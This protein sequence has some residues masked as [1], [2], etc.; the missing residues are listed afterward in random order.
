MRRGKVVLALVA[1]LATVASAQVLEVILETN[2]DPVMAG[3]GDV[4]FDVMVYVQMTGTMGGVESLDISIVTVE[5]NASAEAREVIV[6]FPPPP[7]G[8]GMAVWEWNIA[9]MSGYLQIDPT[10]TDVEPDNDMDTKNIAAAAKTSN[11]NFTLGTTDDYSSLPD[12]D[13]VG[14]AGWVCHGLPPCHLT[15]IV[16]KAYYYN[17]MGEGEQLDPGQIIVQGVE[18]NIPEPATLVLLG[19]SGLFLRR[20]K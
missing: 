10:W 12:K 3:P 20:R 14:T 16:N 8:N 17:A 1:L 5:P 7:H 9:E 18:V 11:T 15:A 19:L 13:L 2:P 6:A 4:D